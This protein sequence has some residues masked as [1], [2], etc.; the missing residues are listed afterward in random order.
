MLSRFEGVTL[1]KRDVNF[2]RTIRVLSISSRSQTLALGNEVGLI[3]D[4]DPGINY[5]PRG[6]NVVVNAWS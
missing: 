2:I 3:K 6:V 5:Y 4:Y 1:W